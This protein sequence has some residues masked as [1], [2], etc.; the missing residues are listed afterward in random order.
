V[1]SEEKWKRDLKQLEM[2]KVRLPQ[3]LSMRAL[4]YWSN[5]MYRGVLVPERDDEREGCV[6]VCTARQEDI[7]FAIFAADRLPLTPK[8]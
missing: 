6:T 3:Y 7:Q 1:L 2:D 4:S 8:R 5:K